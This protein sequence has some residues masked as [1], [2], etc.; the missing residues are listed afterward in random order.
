MSSKGYVKDDWQMGGVALAVLRDRPSGARE[1]LTWVA[2][3]VKVLD[4]EG[5]ASDPAERWDSWLRIPE[6][7]ARALYEALGEHFGHAGHDIRAL[8][9]DYDAERGRVDRLIGHIT[10]THAS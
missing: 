10:G 9:K 7:D 2:G 3:E 4:R 6:E 8:R 1:L 5:S